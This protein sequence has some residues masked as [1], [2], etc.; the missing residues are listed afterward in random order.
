MEPETRS[1]LY[2]AAVCV[3]ACA[4]VAL[5]AHTAQAAQAARTVH[6]AFI[7][8]S[9]VKFGLLTAGVMLGELLPIKVPRR[10]SG[11][12]EEIT[13][14]AS[15]AMALL[16]IGGLGPAIIAQCVASIVQDIHAHKPGWRVRFNAGQYTLSMVAAWTAA[17]LISP[18]S[19][20]GVHHPQLSVMLAAAGTFFI[21]NTGLVGIAIATYQGVRISG[22]F[23]NNLS[24][25]VFT[26]GLMLLL[27]PI[28]LAA[29]EYSTALVPLCLAPIAGLYGT[30]SRGTRSAHAAR[31]D[32]LTELLN[33]AAFHEAVAA[34]VGD[35]RVPA[36]VMLIDLDRFKEVNDTLGHRCGDLL[37]VQVA[38][39]FRD[40]VG[41]DGHIARLGGDEFAIV[42]PGYG[43]ESA[44]LLAE[45][46]SR[47]LRDPFE[48]D[49]M[50]VDVQASIGIALF[51]EHGSD[52]EV[53]LQKADV[54]MYR[55]KEIAEAFTL[56]D[57]QHDHNSPARLALT[58][59]LR[60][61]LATDEIIVWY[62][63]E[64]DIES[65]RVLAVEALVRWEHP[66]LGVLPPDSFIRMAEQTSLIKPLTDRVLD[67]ALHQVARW[68]EDGLDLTVAVNISPRVLVDRAFTD[69]VVSALRRAEVPPSR[70]KLEVTES[71]LMSDPVSAREV[72]EELHRL[73]V[74]ISI[75]DFGTGYSSLAYLA[76]LPVSEV[77]IDR[78]FVSR[79]AES[80]NGKVIVTSTINLAHHLG[81]QA[82]AEGVEDLGLLL[83]LEQLGCDAAQGFGISQPIPAGELTPWVIEF[84]AGAGA[85]VADMAVWKQTDSAEV[86]RPDV[87]NSLALG[88][89]R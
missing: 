20:D 47:C 37:L 51:P 44:A 3:A 89:Q 27:A 54:A 30:I 17:R 46:L 13:L 72:L 75:D 8:H 23:Q 48:L 71:A 40:G 77:K 85:E 78:S 22:Y 68:R 38:K 82:V 21:V 80:P 29:A 81:M 28:V 5:L 65:G 67:L 62:Q 88:G 33:R 1:K 76:D 18:H 39:R 58:A 4:A 74:V 59:E 42:C 41:S 15:F 57:E 2:C 19:L 50:V 79:M 69:K 56:Y 53:L 55:A 45:R 11:E 16:L 6:L 25:V 31:H 61:A 9:P 84:N 64:L 10:G 52:V 24:F 43:P 86:L 12:D 63:P 60:T 87:D 66:N 35:A 83:E 7:A 34:V 73:G 70:L 49:P 32:S 14:S 26:G 36:A